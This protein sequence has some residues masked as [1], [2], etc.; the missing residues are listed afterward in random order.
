MIVTIL[1]NGGWRRLTSAALTLSRAEPGSS[2][3]MRSRYHDGDRELISSLQAIAHREVRRCESSGELA[4]PSNVPGYI[5]RSTHPF[6]GLRTLRMTLPAI[7]IRDKNTSCLPFW[8]SAE[9]SSVSRL[10][11][12]LLQN[13]IDLIS[14]NLATA[15]A[16][17]TCDEQASIGWCSPENLSR[18]S[19]SVVVLSVAFPLELTPGIL[20]NNGGYHR[21]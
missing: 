19:L 13:P 20:R 2:G 12:T 16:G 8:Q 18:S 10:S 15:I 17:G 14:A 4:E 21:F 9:D 3:G 1:S 6:H 7:A 5:S 11:G